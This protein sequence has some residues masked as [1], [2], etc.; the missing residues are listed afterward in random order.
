MKTRVHNEPISIIIPAYNEADF[1]GYVLYSLSRQ[2]FRQ[3]EVILSDANSTDET[4]SIARSYKKQLPCLKIVVPKDG[5]R[6]ATI[7][8][9]NG[10]KSARYEK[11]LFLDADTLLPPDF[12][13]NNLAEIQRKR[14]DCAHPVT[15]PLSKRI[16]DQYVYLLTN[17]GVTLTQKFLPLAGGWAIFSTK[18]FHN[19]ING[20]DEQLTK[21]YDDVDYVSRIVKNG[22]K[23]GIIK[24]AAPYMFA[25]RLDKEGIRGALK[26]MIVQGIYMGLFGKYKM[27]KLIERSQGDFHTNQ[28]GV[29]KKVSKPYHDLSDLLPD[30]VRKIWKEIK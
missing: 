4:V 22:G 27:Q 9:N 19:K 2:T 15:L 29:N 8:R 26:N 28:K 18:T 17:W 23:F 13:E 1:I 21:I 5:R 25:R 10:A 16:L 3:F 24:S 20:F 6:C 7:Q 30:S 12:L 11:L 14:L